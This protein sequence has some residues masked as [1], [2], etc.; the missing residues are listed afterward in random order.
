MQCDYWSSMLCHYSLHI[1]QVSCCLERSEYF[2]TCIE[3]CCVLKHFEKRF[4]FDIRQ[5]KPQLCHLQVI[6]HHWFLPMSISF[7]CSSHR[8]VGELVWECS[9]DNHLNDF[10]ATVVISVL[11][12]CPFNY[13][14]TFEATAGKAH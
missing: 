14:F 3:F 9:Y 1:V 6:E 10:Y 4:S 7:F 8:A 2:I 12:S 11:G 13:F 5:L